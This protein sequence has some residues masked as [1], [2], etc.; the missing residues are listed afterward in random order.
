MTE[1]TQFEEN[2]SDNLLFSALGG[3]CAVIVGLAIF[4][5][6]SLN[7]TASRTPASEIPAQEFTTDLPV[8]E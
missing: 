2:M 6:Q 7:P 4:G 1:D 8:L 5:T 3:I